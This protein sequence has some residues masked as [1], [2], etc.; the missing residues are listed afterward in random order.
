M[1]I[2]YRINLPA[3]KKFFLCP[4]KRFLPAFP[5]FPPC[6]SSCDMRRME[7]R[8]E[9]AKA[10]VHLSRFPL[11]V[12]T[13]TNGGRKC[14]CRM[15]VQGKEEDFRRADRLRMREQTG[16]GFRQWRRKVFPLPLLLPLLPAGNR[17]WT[18]RCLAY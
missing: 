6:L 18:R 16:R 1:Q 7:C 5:F 3:G 17:F 13:K 9:S 4:E 2:L 12:Q 14:G 8:E 10:G 15:N 11:C